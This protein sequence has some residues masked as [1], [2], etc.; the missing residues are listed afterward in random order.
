[1]EEKMPPSWS[2]NAEW[3]TLDFGSPEERACFG[4]IGIYANN[5]CLTEGNDVLANRLRQ[6]PLLSGYHLAEWLAWNWWR[7]RW[8]PRSR[9]AD[10]NSAHRLATIG[11]GYIWP[12]ITIFSDGERTALIAKPTDERKQTP[13]RFITDRGVVVPA[14][15]FEAGLDAFIEQVFERLTVREIKESNLHS[16]WGGVQ[17]ERR[18]PELS[19][20]RKLEALLGDDPDEANPET[21]EQLT[22]DARELTIPAIEELAA[23]HGQ[24]HLIFTASDLRKI[25]LDQGRSSSSRNAVRLERSAELR[26]GKD[27]PAWQVGADAARMLREQEGLGSS[28]ISDHRLAEMAG[29]DAEIVNDLHGSAP[30]SFSLD[31]TPA[32]GRTVLRSKWHTGRRFE[33]ARILGDRV[34]GPKGEKLFP[35]TRADTYR[36]KLQRSFAAELLSP[37]AALEDLLGGDYSSEKQL[38]AAEHFKVSERTIATLLVNHG[39]IDR[40]DLDSEIELAA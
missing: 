2:I 9:A 21:L 6:A 17:E 32:D 10:W 29:V 34:A 31:S 20:T 19:L 5:L 1:V 15:D 11:H 39:R 26:R 38:D 3:E 28:M 14:S 35:A 30:I 22:A 40:E 7:L 13:F 12:N 24:S 4:A 8:E 27:R 36:Q 33:L 16:V 37:F 23:E 25:A 18:S